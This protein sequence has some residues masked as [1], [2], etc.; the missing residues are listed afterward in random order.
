MKQTLKLFIKL[1]QHSKDFFAS[2]AWRK[3]TKDHWSILELVEESYKFFFFFLISWKTWY[4]TLLTF[5]AY[6]QTSQWIGDTHCR[7]TCLRSVQQNLAFGS[8]RRPLTN[9]MTL[10]CFLNWEKT[11]AW[12]LWTLAQNSILD[13]QRGTQTGPHSTG[14]SLYFTLR[15]RKEVEEDFISYKRIG[16]CSTLWQEFVFYHPGGP[17]LECTYWLIVSNKDILWF[18][19]L[20]V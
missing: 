19:F 2:W 12:Q 4:T 18:F 6:D 17:S 20:Y 7:A 3:Q 14:L 5:V 13:R 15:N 11:T 16:A 8:P 10:L 1:I 9:Q